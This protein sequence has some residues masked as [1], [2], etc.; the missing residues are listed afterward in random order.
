MEF[1][2]DSFGKVN[3]QDVTRY[4]ISNDNNVKISVLNYG[5]IWQQ[6]SIPSNNDHFN[7]LLAADSIEDYLDAG[8]SI[9]QLIGP[10]AN[11][12]DQ[13]KFSIDDKEYSLEKNEGNNNIHS[14][15]KGWQNHF[16]DVKAEIDKNSAHLILHNNYSPTADGM[17]ANTDIYVVY[18]LRNDDSVTIDL[19]GQTDA[20]TLFNPT[21]HTYWNLSETDL[22][23][24][25][26]IL[27]IN[28]DYHLA[29]NKE[30]IPTG[31]LVKNTNAY[32]FKKGQR[33]E[34]AL[35]EMNKTPEKG[36][37]DFF[38]VTPSSTYAG[39][40]IASLANPVTNLKMRM[41]SDRNA[42]VM[43][44]ANGLPNTVKLNHPGC[45]WAAL[46]LEAQTLP[47]APH[48]PEFGDIT[49]RPLAPV[50]HWIKYEIEY[51]GQKLS[52]S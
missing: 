45:S 35:I 3:D 47:D 18:T 24:E 1:F 27:T 37:D 40:E 15:S 49:M 14:G 5:G 17:P 34:N 21:S 33:L 7:M 46:A 25:K 10:V 11:R 28:S 19:Y 36:F 42:L 20:P 39:K 43:F 30:K 51:P 50:H 9:G 52:K 4:T 29:V 44:S 23:I 12:I 22:T 6:Y 16:W 48:H 31:E 8:Y 26:Q 32:D 38:V 41:Y 2:E 13:A